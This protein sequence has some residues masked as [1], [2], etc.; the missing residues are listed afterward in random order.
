M[1]E[2]NGNDHQDDP[3]RNVEQSPSPIERLHPAVNDSTSSDNGNHKKANWPQRIEAVCA[4][5]LVL[6]T[7][8]YTYY[9]RGQLRLTR[10]ALRQSKSA[11]AN[12][13]K[14]QQQI[15]QDSLAKS[16]DNFA[17]TSQTA[18]E[19]F[20]DEQRAWVGAL[21]V[22]NVIIKE[23]APPVFGV[24][25]TNSGKTPALHVRFLT[26]GGSRMRGEQSNFAYPPL[27]KDQIVSDFV[28]QPG[29]QYTLN[30]GIPEQSATKPQVDAITS[31]TTIFWIYGKVR[32]EDV[33]KRIHHTKFCF[34]LATDLKTGQPCSTYNEAD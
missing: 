9:T 8:T 15:A 11:N 24:V 18:E 27:P 34:L 13:I 19:T 30:S 33:S 5:L 2:L 28:L 14:A 6:I 31:G 10:E 25:V 17:K 7:G 12:A 22:T 21:G 32:Y 3:N 16:Q 20:R 1:N 23:G 29:S 4:I 26:T